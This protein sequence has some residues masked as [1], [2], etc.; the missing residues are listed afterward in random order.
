M[1]AK[2]APGWDLIVVGGGAAGFFGAI[3]ASEKKAGLRVL[4]VEKARKNLGKVLI[5]GGGRCNVTHACFDPARLV[6]FYPRGGAA[7]RGPFNRFHPSHTVAWFQQ[8]GAALKTESDGRIFPVSDSST[9]IADTLQHAARQAGVVIW[10]QTAVVKIVQNP[11]EGSFELWLRHPGGENSQVSC[12]AVLLA[13]GGEQGGFLLAQSLGHQIEPPVPSL[14]T[15]N[16][17]DPRLDGLAGVSVPIVQLT[18]LNPAGK[19]AS[20]G[21]KPLQPQTGPVLIT[22]WGLSGPAV[23]RLSAWGAR[24]LANSRYHANLQVNWLHPLATGEA[25]SALQ[26]FKNSPTTNRK[27]P[28]AHSPFDSMPQRLWKRFVE[29]AGIT[30][31]QNWADLSR[32]QL[33][34]LAEE[35]T[36]GRYPIR[37]KG[38]FKEEF[39]TC[40][41]VSLD[42]VDFKTMQSRLIPGL[43]FAGEVLDID[44]LTGGFNFQAAWTTSW[45]AGQAAA[46]QL[47]KAPLGA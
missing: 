46:E 23:L 44:G 20:A 5:S 22:H 27:K 39:V 36:A 24:S 30:E 45:I 31:T 8:R 47:Q 35:L 4:I 33:T 19:P 26:A 1:I 14:F 15:F 28:V 21:K 42:Q 40:G 34:H 7:L 13:T 41:G 37:G 29:T 32:S 18:L 3:A 2:P 6:E 38:P 10:N 16:I 25:L 12:R 11:G 17:K 9:T 43:F